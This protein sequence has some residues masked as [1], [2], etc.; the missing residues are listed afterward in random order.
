MQSNLT[1]KKAFY[2]VR[3][4]PSIEQ[5]W[6]S[7]KFLETLEL[8]KSN[9]PSESLM[10]QALFEIHHIRLI[11]LCLVTALEVDTT[12]ISIL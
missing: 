4:P 2:S 9:T 8:M 1:Q 6:R 3:Q 12:V 11:H 10:C 5:C 7:R